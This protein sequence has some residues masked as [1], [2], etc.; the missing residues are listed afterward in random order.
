LAGGVGRKGTPTRS[1][2]DGVLKQIAAALP[3]PKLICRGPAYAA[4]GCPRANQV[5]V[6]TLIDPTPSGVCKAD[7][8]TGALKLEIGAPS[9]NIRCLE[10]RM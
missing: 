6:Y 9:A 8:V 2:V 3:Q 7:A 1:C 4:G 10:G 5:P